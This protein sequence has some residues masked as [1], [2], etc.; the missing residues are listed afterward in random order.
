MLRLTTTRGSLARWQAIASSL[1][2][3]DLV[4][5]E[6]AFERL[7]LDYD[8]VFSTMGIPACLWRRTGEIYKGNKEFADLVGVSIDSLRDGK[9][10]IYE[11]SL[12]IAENVAWDP[13]LSS[14]T[15]LL[16]EESAANYW[17]KYGSIAFNSGQKAVLTSCVLVHQ[18]RLAQHKSRSSSSRSSRNPDGNEP[19]SVVPREACLNCTF[20]FTVR[21]DSANS[22]FP[23]AQG[24][25]TR[26]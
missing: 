17:E 12:V 4:L 2:D 22:E 24:Q 23:F 6:E 13:L 21:R 11:V 3:L 5:I 18:T 9:L 25:C 16:A 26:Q 20:S 7:L 14:R 8:R 19:A 10:A 1:T 15:Q